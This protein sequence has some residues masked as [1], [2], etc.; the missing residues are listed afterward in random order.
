MSEKKRRPFGRGL[1]VVMRPVPSG[2]KIPKKKKK[3]KKKKKCCAAAHARGARMCQ[4]THYCFRVHLRAL[5]LSGRDRY[6]A[7]CL[8]SPARSSAAAATA[9]AALFAPRLYV[10][11]QSDERLGCCVVDVCTAAAAAA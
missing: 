3:K 10:A 6:A 11:A 9:R 4:C 1:P 5:L 8:I 7:R 2:K